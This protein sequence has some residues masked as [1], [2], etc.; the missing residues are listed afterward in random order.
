MR[1]TY[2]NTYNL[3]TDDINKSALIEV[4]SDSLTQ[5]ERDYF[6]DQRHKHFLMTVS[7]LSDEP[8]E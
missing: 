7:I 6:L 2:I 3:M 4:K 5:K 8:P 1:D